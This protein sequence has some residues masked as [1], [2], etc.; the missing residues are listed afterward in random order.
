MAFAKAKVWQLSC[1]GNRN[2]V[3]ACG[4]GGGA[5]KLLAP[6]GRD[7]VAVGRNYARTVALLRKSCQLSRRR[8]WGGP[9]PYPI[10]VPAQLLL[11]ETEHGQLC[12]APGPVTRLLRLFALRASSSSLAQVTK[13]LAPEGVVPP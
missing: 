1:L 4:L 5:A 9:R 6:K 8:D 11:S 2:V 12:T 13:L 10:G 3:P 7:W